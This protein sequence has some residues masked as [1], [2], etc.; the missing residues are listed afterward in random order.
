MNICF[1][2]CKICNRY[3]Q[4]FNTILFT[5]FES[6][7]ALIIHSSMHNYKYI[8]MF[9]LS[10]KRKDDVPFSFTAHRDT[11]L[12]AVLHTTVILQFY[13]FT[14]PLFHSSH[15]YSRVRIIIRNV[16]FRNACRSHKLNNSKI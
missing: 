2:F 10:R 6:F 8:N 3:N 16:S 11:I 7:I 14:I 15:I 12:Y 4:I 9:F 13:L 1:L 5:T